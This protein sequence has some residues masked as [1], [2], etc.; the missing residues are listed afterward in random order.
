[1]KQGSPLGEPAMGGTR[2]PWADL[3]ALV[4]SL[5]PGVGAECPGP[6]SFSLAAVSHDVLRPADAETITAALQGAGL[7]ADGKQGALVQ[8]GPRIFLGV[9]QISQEDS[10]FHAEVSQSRPNPRSIAS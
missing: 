2:S 7:T 3:P 4:S 9:L 1:M 6:L 8:D 10:H 5:S